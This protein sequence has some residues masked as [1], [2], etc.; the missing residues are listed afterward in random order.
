MKTLHI[1]DGSGEVV[2]FGEV[3]EVQAFVTTERG[4]TTTDTLTATLYGPDGDTVVPGA[5]EVI[6]RARGEYLVAVAMP[7][8]PGR[9]RLQ[10]AGTDR[11]AWATCTVDD[12][13]T[14]IPDLADLQEFLGT[15]LSAQ[16]GAE[17]IQRA[18]DEEIRA[19]ADACTIPAA[20][21]ASLARALRRRVQVNLAM[22][23]Q[24]LA[25]ADFG[26]TPVRL[27]ATDPIV[28][29]LE[30]RWPKSPTG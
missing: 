23:G 7:E 22:D 18:L 2:T 1:G 8:T 10:L 26:E 27:P 3:W 29:R 19:Q 25:V 13:F 28:R 30:S 24:P 20:Y 14:S 16:Y 4:H 5:A 12:P 17:K 6:Y 15:A 11:T 9:Y 21:P